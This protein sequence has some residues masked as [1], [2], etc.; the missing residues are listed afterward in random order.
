ML[1]RKLKTPRQVAVIGIPIFS[2]LFVI[3]FFGSGFSYV[4]LNK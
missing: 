3:I 1:E 4:S 2:I